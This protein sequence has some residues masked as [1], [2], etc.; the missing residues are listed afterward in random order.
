MDLSPYENLIERVGE[1][2]ADELLMRMRNGSAIANGLAIYLAFYIDF[3]DFA[4]LAQ[5]PIIGFIIKLIGLT[6]LNVILWKVGG[7][8]KWKVRIILLL[9]FIFE[10]IPVVGILPIYTLSMIWAHF[11]IKHDAQHAREELEEQ[12]F[13]VD[14]HED[15]V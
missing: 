7:H 10:I 11:K 12:G 4:L 6:I 1:D 13:P 2:I 15:F 3:F 5:I 14:E 9:A 8:I